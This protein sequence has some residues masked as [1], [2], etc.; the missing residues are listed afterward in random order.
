M[1]NNSA[2]TG[3]PSVC[4]NKDIPISPKA[5]NELPLTAFDDNQNLI[6]FFITEQSQ[7]NAIYAFCEK[8][9]CIEI[10]NFYSDLQILKDIKDEDKEQWNA[11]LNKI[12]RSYLMDQNPQAK[13]INVSHDSKTAF[14]A[15]KDSGIENRVEI[16]E[17]LENM[18]NDIW[19]NMV[20]PMTGLVK[21]VREAGGEKAINDAKITN[22]N[23]NRIQYKG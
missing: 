4:S 7:V 18:R 9:L 16:Q 11:Q 19:V 12:Y 17:A 1:N 3:S 23:T 14:T 6:K 15:I 5:F 8:N 22:S 21:T 20:K 2:R 10:I 13:L